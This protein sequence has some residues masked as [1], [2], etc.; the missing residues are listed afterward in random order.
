MTDLSKAF[1]CPNHEFLIAKLNSCGFTLLALK[2]IDYYLSNKKQ[3]KKI[4]S[5]HSKW[6]EI[7]F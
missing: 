1:D 6:L 7:I 3:R 5:S 2:I 4:N